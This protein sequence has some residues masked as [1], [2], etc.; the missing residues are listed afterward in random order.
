MH[1][2]TIRLSQKL[3][4]LTNFNSM[5]KLSQLFNSIKIGTPKY[6]KFDRGHERLLTCKAGKLIPFYVDEVIPG[7]K[8]RVRTDVMMRLMPMLA[9][10][11]HRMNVKME[12]FYVPNRIVWE[13]WNNFIF[14]GPDGTALPVMPHFDLSLLSE[15]ELAFFTA[16]TLSDFLGFAMDGVSFPVNDNVKISAL[17]F[18]AYQLIFNEFYRDQNLESALNIPKTSGSIV[19]AEFATLTALRDSAWEKDYF[20]SALPW[21]QRGPEAVIPV[22]G[23]GEAIYRPQPPGFINPLLTRVDGAGDPAAGGLNT[24]GGPSSTLRDSANNVLNLDNIDHVEMSAV[25]VSINDLRRTTRLQEWLEKNARGGARAIEQLLVHFGVKSSDARLQRPE[26]L[27]GGTVP[28]RITEVLSTFQDDAGLLPQGNMSGHGVGYGNSRGFKRFFEEHGHVIGVLRILPRTVYGNG[29][30]RSMTR[31]DKFDYYWRDFANL[32]EQEIK[33]KE[34]FFDT[35]QTAG[36]GEGTFGYQSRYSEY[37][38]A[39][40]TIHGAFR[41]NLSFWHMARLFSTTPVLNSSFV[42]ADPTTRIFAVDDPNEDHYIMNVY[43][44]VDALRQIPYFGTPHL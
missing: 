41:G 31:F 39:P 7:D 9:P 33:N 12:Y 23:E 18:R 32:G 30:P 40:S 21:S 5:A 8:F 19:G 24:G 38:Y 11:M 29:I 2:R 34:L 6:N 37:K 4:L 28:V 14:G 25:N 26:Y 20:T 27:G 22:E 13:E 1:G 36:T 15:T 35:G 16:N 3:M 17:R 42:K 10:A 43:N 44:H